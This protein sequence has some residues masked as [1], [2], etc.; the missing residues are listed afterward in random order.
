[1]RILVALIAVFMVSVAVAQKKPT[2]PS[3]NCEYAGTCSFSCQF[4]SKGP[5]GPIYACKDPKTAKTQ[6][7]GCKNPPKQKLPPKL[8][9]AELDQ[10]CG[11]LLDTEPPTP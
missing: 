8:S 6:K 1:M 5:S 11:I 9:V 2:I 10:A 4:K 3:Y 7:V